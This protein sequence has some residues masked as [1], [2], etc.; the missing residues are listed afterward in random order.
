VDESN[1]GE[2]HIARENQEDNWMTAEEIE[3]IKT[4][5]NEYGNVVKFIVMPAREDKPGKIL[6]VFQS[7]DDAAKLTDQMNVAENKEDGAM[8]GVFDMVGKKL[9][10][11]RKAGRN[12]TAG[13]TNLKAVFIRNLNY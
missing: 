8:D 9:K 10:F 12:S 11:Y 7:M 5:F 4:K 1:S 3:E 13:L 2:V 6:A